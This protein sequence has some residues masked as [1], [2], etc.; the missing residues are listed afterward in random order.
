MGRYL[1]FDTNTID[2]ATRADVSWK[3][4]YF[5]DFVFGGERDQRVYGLVKITP[6]MSIE[7]DVNGLKALQWVLGSLATN[8]ITVSEPTEIG[9]VSCS[10]ET[11]S[12]GISFAKVNDWE[13]NIEEGNPI[14]AVM[15]FIGKNTVTTGPSSYA[16]DF[17]STAMLPSQ[18]YCTIGAASIDFSKI[19]LKIN[20]DIAT[21][22]KTNVLPVTLRPQGLQIDG[23]LRVPSYMDSSVVDGAM[24]IG[25]LGVGTICLP[26]V[27]FMEI[28]AK[29]KGYDIPDTEYSFSAFPAAATSAIKVILGNTLKW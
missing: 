28:P 17:S 25:L 26:T 4:D 20:N 21:I 1:K 24:T 12:A 22:F 18:C 13:I 15:N 2:F 19:S 7:Y 10:V 3:K 16:A 23:K 11:Q 14:T 8:T 27:K 29:A 6:E 9:T 5:K